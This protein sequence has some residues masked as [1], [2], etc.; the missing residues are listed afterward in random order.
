[1]SQ[2]TTEYRR[3]IDLMSNDRNKSRVQLQIQSEVNSEL[4]D[5]R[6]SLFRWCRSCL[7]VIWSRWQSAGLATGLSANSATKRICLP[8]KCNKNAVH[9]WNENEHL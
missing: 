6:C 1:M 8:C 9:A 2:I 3:T 7:N 5:S 4:S